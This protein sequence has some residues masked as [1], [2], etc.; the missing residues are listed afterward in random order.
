MSRAIQRT[1]QEALDK[2]V[3]QKLQ[4]DV[5][6]CMET[7]INAQISADKKMQAQALK[8][9]DMYDIKVKE[10]K[11]PDKRVLSI[12]S[13]NIPDE[14][15]ELEPIKAAAMDQ[16]EELWMMAQESHRNNRMS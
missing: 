16:M 8:M 14:S 13:C 11:N 5:S 1:L 4:M 9:G 3:R 6:L 7:A 2:T 12:P 15:I 10:I